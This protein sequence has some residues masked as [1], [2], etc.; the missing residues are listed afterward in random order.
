MIPA[1]LYFVAAVLIEIYSGIAQSLIFVM[2]SQFQTAL[3]YFFN[4]TTIMSPIFPIQDLMAVLIVLLSAWGVKIGIKIILWL[5]GFIP[6]IGHKDLPQILNS[7][8]NTLNLQRHGRNTIDLR[9]TT[10]KGR[11]ARNT[12]DI[13]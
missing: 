9:H 1:I 10:F 13:R 4:A 6:G 12:R 5:I 8:P 7:D 3:A 2:P 11:K